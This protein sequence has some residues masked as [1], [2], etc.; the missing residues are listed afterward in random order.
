MFR[1][2]SY[3]KPLRN[4]VLPARFPVRLQL[5]AL[6]TRADPHNR[7]A[8]RWLQRRFGDGGYYTM[9][10]RLLSGEPVILLHLPSVDAAG[11][12]LFDNP[13]V[14]LIRERWEGAMR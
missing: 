4:D 3:K 8:H 1:A 6:G 14:R 5:A 2:V 11:A 7:Q 10:A 13:G 12:F 9:P